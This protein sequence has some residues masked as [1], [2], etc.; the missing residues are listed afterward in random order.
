MWHYKSDSIYKLKQ[1][2][3][4][5]GGH[6]FLLYCWLRLQIL[7]KSFFS[8]ININISTRKSTLKVLLKKLISKFRHFALSIYFIQWLYFKEKKKCK[9]TCH[10]HWAT[11]WDTYPHR[12]ERWPDPCAFVQGHHRLLS[13]SWWHLE[14]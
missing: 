7:G 3:E 8:T 2:L 1:N 14:H 13:D 12:A 6:S 5:I 9:L 11:S 10:I 4:I